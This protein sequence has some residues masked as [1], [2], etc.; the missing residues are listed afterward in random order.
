MPSILKEH[1]ERIARAHG[2]SLADYQLEA[3]AERVAQDMATAM[4]WTLTVPEQ[5][6]LLEIVLRPAPTTPALEA[7]MSEAAALFGQPD[8]SMPIAGAAGM[9][10]TGKA[11]R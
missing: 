7:A 1:A 8:P 3:L 5:A 11:A 10:A 4:T 6:T 9:P 2:Q